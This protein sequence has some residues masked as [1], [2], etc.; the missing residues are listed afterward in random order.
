MH[1]FVTLTHWN[2]EKKDRKKCTTGAREF[3]TLLVPKNVSIVENHLFIESPTT[4][5][6]VD[7]G[8]RKKKKVNLLKFNKYLKPFSNNLGCG[9][10]CPCK[11]HE[12]AKVTSPAVDLA[13]LT[14]NANQEKFDKKIVRNS[15]PKTS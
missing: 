3:V 12:E 1:R 2:F 10:S 5:L 11:C 7:G 13:L 9:V 4:G 15:I 8:I 6:G 14:A